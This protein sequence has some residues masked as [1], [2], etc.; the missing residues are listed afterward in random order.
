MDVVN[1]LYPFKDIPLSFEKG[2]PLYLKIVKNE[3]GEKEPT[4]LLSA[5]A[6]T[7]GG[8]GVWF[9]EN[10]TVGE[11]FPRSLAIER[12]PALLGG[13]FAPPVSYWWGER[14]REPGLRCSRAGRRKAGTGERTRV[15]GRRS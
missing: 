7:C 13:V 14:T 8:L 6:V 4:T 3:P 10:F 15:Q 5:R 11:S 12:W 1:T 2:T 9:F